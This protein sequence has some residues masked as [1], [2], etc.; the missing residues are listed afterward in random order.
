MS[1]GRI[2]ICHRRPSQ[3]ALGAQAVVWWKNRVGSD[4]PES[5]EMMSLARAPFP[6]LLTLP[7]DQVRRTRGDE[8]LSR[9]LITLLTA[10]AR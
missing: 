1:S 7:S 6:Q 8:R 3:L 4:S 5:P 9:R 10:S 2:T